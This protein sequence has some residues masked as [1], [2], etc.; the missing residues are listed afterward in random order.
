[1]VQQIREIEG[2]ADVHLT[3]MFQKGKAEAIQAIGEAADLLPR[4]LL[5]WPVQVPAMADVAGS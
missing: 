5:T 1:M 3:A 4:P 2:V